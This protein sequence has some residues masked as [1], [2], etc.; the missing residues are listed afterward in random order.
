M[1][2]RDS[3]VNNAGGKGSDTELVAHQE[4]Q[5]YKGF[6]HFNSPFKC[7]YPFTYFFYVAM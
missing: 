5:I 1:P 4:V 3:V 7:L 6:F 2:T